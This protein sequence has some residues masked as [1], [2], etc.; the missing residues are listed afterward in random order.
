M[1]LLMAAAHARVAANATAVALARAQRD[2]HRR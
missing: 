2:E 1:S